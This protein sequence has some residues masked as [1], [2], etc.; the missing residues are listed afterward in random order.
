MFSRVRQFFD[1]HDACEMIARALVRQRGRN[2]LV[3][4]TKPFR[5]AEVIIGI[6]SD[7]CVIACAHAPDGQLTLH[8]VSVF[9]SHLVLP[10]L[11]ARARRDEASS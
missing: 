5:N 10:S 1:A 7:A 11:S 3:S 8:V 4:L 9:L 6:Y 2:D